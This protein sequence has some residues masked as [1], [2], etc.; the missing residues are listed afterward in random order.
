[1]P[2]INVNG[3]ELFYSEQGNGSETMVFAHGLL[4]DSSMWDFVAPEFAD[5]YRVICFDFR[6]QGQSRHPGHGFSIDNLVKDTAALIQ[7]LTDRPVHYVGLSMGGM[8][9]MPLA[10]RYP[11]LLRSLILLDTSAQAEPT[12]NKI[13]Y[14]LM[15]AVVKTFGVKALT[16]RT[17]PLMFGASTM[18]NPAMRELV[19]HWKHK[20]D[21]LKKSITG[22]VS[23][24]TRRRD[25][26]QEL[27]KII[28]PTFIMVGEEDRTTPVSCARHIHVH[29]PHSELKIIPLCGHSSALE[30]PGQV[31]VAMKDFYSRL[32]F[33]A[34]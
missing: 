19:N 15:T 7:A 5:V 21:G 34:G 8:V 1:M 6:G 32:F 18:K 2:T 13:K 29:I 16:S 33:A 3:V 26:T 10:A 11:E 28:C 12:K 14:A 22:P 31:L 17:L 4:M 9:G 24:V 25:A 20:L 23:G 30:K 27:V